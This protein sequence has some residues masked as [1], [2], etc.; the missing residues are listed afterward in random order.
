M[1]EARGRLQ[2]KHCDQLVGIISRMMTIGIIRLGILDD[3]KMVMNLQ[4]ILIMSIYIVTG[5]PILDLTTI[6]DL[7]KVHDKFDHRL[8]VTIDQN[9]DHLFQQQNLWW[10]MT[11]MLGLLGHAPVLWIEN[12]GLDRVLWSDPKDQ[13]HHDDL[14]HLYQPNDID[15]LHP[16]QI[17]ENLL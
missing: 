16:N 1:N 3:T 9:L 2:G 5:N 4:E 7:D 12:E 14:D 11:S 13:L 10:L 8:A 6:K 15:H 17:V